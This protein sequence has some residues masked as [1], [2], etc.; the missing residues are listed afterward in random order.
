MILIGISCVTMALD[1]PTLERES[2]LAQV[3]DYVDMAVTILFAIEMA[4]KLTLKV[5]RRTALMRP[6]PSAG[7][8]PDACCWQHKS[9]APTGHSFGA[10]PRMYRTSWIKIATSTT[11]AGREPVSDL[12]A[13]HVLQGWV[14]HRAAY[15][16]TSWDILDGIITIVCLLALFLQNVGFFRT[17]RLLRCLRPLRMI[18]RQASK[19]IPP[20]APDDAR[21]GQGWPAGWCGWR[22]VGSQCK[23]R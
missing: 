9:M 1:E 19:H 12:C 17:L 7:T 20:T 22:H 18:S 14:G 8:L 21:G 3:L 16:R 2:T 11:G 10:L 5:R 13:L 15:W 6:P 23:Q 4:M